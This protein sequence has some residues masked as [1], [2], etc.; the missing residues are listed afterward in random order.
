[1]PV[2]GLETRVNSFRLKSYDVEDFSI[3]NWLQRWYVF[4]IGLMAVSAKELC[5]MALAMP[6]FGLET[7]VKS[8]RLKSYD[9]EDFSIESGG[10]NGGKSS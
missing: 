2:F 7:R 4:V 5:T 1:M 8:F 9:V 3:E 10:Y 6:V